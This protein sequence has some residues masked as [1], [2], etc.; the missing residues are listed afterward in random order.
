VTTE[1]EEQPE[2][3]AESEEVQRLRAALDEI[4]GLRVEEDLVRA[5]AL[6]DASFAEAR[7][8]FEEIVR[9]VGKLQPLA[10]AKL[11]PSPVNNVAKHAENLRDAVQQVRDFTLQQADPLSVRDSVSQQVR[12]NF[13]ALRAQAIPLVGFLSW[14]A[15]NLDEMTAEMARLTQEANQR[16]DDVVQAL[17]QKKEEGDRALEA[18]RGV[19]A[20]AGVEFHAETFKAAADRHIADSWWW[21]AASVLSA[22]LTVVAAVA[23]VVLWDVNGDIC[24]VSRK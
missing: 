14:E 17:D 5:R 12:N 6:G 3:E 15:I 8:L 24:P 7:P 20:T 19:A 13:D 1:E 21:L 22:I 11:P 16:V 18:I 10:W 9:F 2:E 4:A 23:L